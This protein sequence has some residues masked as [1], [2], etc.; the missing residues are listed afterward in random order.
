MSAGF[1]LG[2]SCEA[3]EAVV[4]AFIGQAE[5]AQ[6]ELPGVCVGAIALV[7]ANALACFV[8]HALRDEALGAEPGGVDLARESV[9]R[10]AEGGK[11]CFAHEAVHALC[12]EEVE[13]A[14]HVEPVP[15]W[16]AEIGE[17]GAT[18]V[19]HFAEEDATRHEEFRDVLRDQQR[20]NAVLHRV[21]HHDKVEGLIC[22]GTWNVFA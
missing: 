7:W 8:V 14:R 11:A 18:V 1:D 13:M 19:G 10:C 17:T 22:E 16:A 9:M 20:I 3:A 5:V 4:L 6:G 15:R 12:R 2:L 21:V